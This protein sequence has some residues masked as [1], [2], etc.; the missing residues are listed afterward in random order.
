MKAGGN[1]AAAK[2]WQKTAGRTL[3]NSTDAKVKYPKDLCQKY[4]EIVKSRAQADAAQQS[5]LVHLCLPAY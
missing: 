5:V 3:A 4:T 1:E 2:F